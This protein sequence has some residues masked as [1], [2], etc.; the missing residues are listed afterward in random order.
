VD[1]PERRVRVDIFERRTAFLGTLE[2]F[3]TRAAEVREMR[4]TMVRRMKGKKALRQ[5]RRI[6]E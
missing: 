4:A 1:L 6:I 2:G 3:V 5:W